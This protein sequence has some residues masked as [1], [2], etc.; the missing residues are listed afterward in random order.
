MPATV[1][2]L[3]TMATDSNT[4]DVS[5]SDQYLMRRFYIGRDQKAMERLF[6]RHAGTAYRVALRELRNPADAEEIVQSAFLNMLTKGNEKVNNV[7]GWI[8][9]S[10]IN[11][12][13][14]R[15]KEEARRRE[16]QA[17]ATL[18]RVDEEAISGE[19]AELVAAA[20]RM[21]KT[22]PEH[23]RLPVSLHY[24]EGMSVKEVASALALPEDTVSKQARRGIEQLRQSLAAAGFSAV[25]IP[26]L[27]ASS[28]LTSAPATLTASFKTMI[29]SAA[30]KGAATG[31]ASETAKVAGI[32]TSIKIA[33]TAA[34]LL[35][36][37]TAFNSGNGGRDKELK[38]DAEAPPAGS[39]LTPMPAAAQSIDK[40][41]GDILDT[42]I[43]ALYRRDYLSEVLDDLDKRVGL[44]SA[45]PKP[46][47]QSFMFTLEEKQITVR[48]VLENLAVKGKLDLEYHGDEVVFWKKADDKILAQLEK[49]LKEGDIE[50]RCEAVYDLTQLGD[51]R[52]YPLLFHGLCDNQD[53]VVAKAIVE[54][55]GHNSM[56][57]NETVGSSIFEPLSKLLSSPGMAAYKTEL[58]SLLGWSRAPRAIEVL[59]ALSKDT[60]AC[61]RTHAASALGSTRDP[62]AVEPL[63]ALLK[64]TDREVRSNAASVLGNTGDPR[65]VEPLIALLK[66]TV[67]GVR[68]CAASALGNTRDPRAVEPL[69]VLLKDT[70][71]IV[72][73]NAADALGTTRTPRAFE[74]LVALAKDNDTH[75]R[76][77]AECALGKTG[78]AR[79]VE[80]LIALMT[81]KDSDAYVRS[82]AAYALALSHTHNPRAIEPLI[83]LSK[84]TDAH[85]R[86]NAASALGNTSDPRAVEPLIALL[87]DTVA[88]VRSCAAY[89]L[90]N[91]R[92]P[93]AVEPLIAL[94]KDMDVTVRDSAAFALSTSR[95]PRAVEPLIALLKDMDVN[96]RASAVV[97]LG[98][99]IDA[100]A[101]KVLIALSKD[102]NAN[103]RLNAAIALDKMHD[104]RAIESLIAL[105]KDTDADVR[106]KATSAMGNT[107]D[108]RAVEP[109]IALMKDT[110][111]GVRSF[112]AYA[113]GNTRDPRAKAALAE[114]EKIKPAPDQPALP[115]PAKATALPSADDF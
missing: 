81:D 46:I 17:L 28:A 26:E 65:A 47:D 6:N 97:K 12:C 14:N 92:D 98:N 43:D 11:A 91:T 16:R 77:I 102:T 19:T 64:D 113:L 63:I 89:A 62:R 74:V 58:M 40:S 33:I 49:K 54:L 57:S 79:A 24:L 35:V 106:C 21:V 30:A 4:T 105:S 82:T 83:A 61:V 48:Q 72:R 101:F 84:E 20:V 69:I 76:S 39:A 41:L 114:Y 15:I 115:K 52:I 22:L 111:P 112:A 107:R 86:S 103:V 93:R 8:M 2:S 37:V 13:R 10:V 88:G 1:L 70:N 42:K 108:P 90:G 109:L 36:V 85:V 87:K 104:P 23:Y 29:A 67:A 45:F 73:I 95:D 44:R 25:L 78:D 68:S 9:G 80:M 59:S 71:D 7:R 55:D 53:V 75:V 99:T 32:A 27:L 100:R 94:L 3:S 96:V 66:D 50:A 38:E 110:V 60:D 5:D 34:M 18:D 31:A 56:L 51:K